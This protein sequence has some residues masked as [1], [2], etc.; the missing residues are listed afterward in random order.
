MAGAILL[1]VSTSVSV[2]EAADDALAVR[3]QGALAR[4]FE[5]PVLG[6]TQVLAEATQQASLRFDLTTEYHASAVGGEA[7]T[8]DGEADLLT[9]G[10]RW[11]LGRN[12]ELGLELPLLHQSGGFMD[13]PIED[14]HSFF[15]LPNGGRELAPKNR[16]L[17]EYSR[18]GDELLRATR[19][20]SDIG[21]LRV[22]GAWGV[23]PSL[24][25]RTELKLPT[26][27]ED[28]LA[29]GNTG[30]ALWADYALPLPDA[31]FLSGWVAGG[32]SVND[33]SSVL[34]DMQKQV[35]PLAGAGLS[36]RLAERWALLTQ[37]YFH[38]ALYDDS[39]LDPF[40]EA[41]QLAIG[42]RYRVRRD[43]NLDIGFQED[44]I[45]SSSPDFSGHLAL[46]WAPF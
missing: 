3:N 9:L 27:N 22:A 14:W 28:H 16:Y 18:D 45:T 37:L 32:L 8:L 30:F 17:Y 39:E 2:A 12:I 35:V 1:P 11:G 24:A 26:G 36:A 34:S 10:W 7:V 4:A 33:E 31:F 21:D 38:G 40:R 41:L 43:M 15:G 46:S 25:L 29:G 6:R 13:G 44:P 5:L 23:T 20:G 19:T 42:L